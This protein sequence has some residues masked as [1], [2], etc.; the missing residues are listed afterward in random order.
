MVGPGDGGEAV[1]SNKAAGAHAASH[2]ARMST[3]APRVNTV[4]AQAGGVA[5][6]ICPGR[7]ANHGDTT[8]SVI[9]PIYPSTTY[10]RDPETYLPRPLMGAARVPNRVVAAAIDAPTSNRREGADDDEGRITTVESAPAHPGKNV[11]ARPDNPTY[12]QAEAV[13]AALDGGVGCALF[14]SGMA[15]A[16]G[17]ATAL[18]KHGDRCVFPRHSYFACREYFRQHCARIGCEFRLYDCRKGK[19]HE[20]LNEGADPRTDEE[21]WRTE[22]SSVETAIGTDGKT[23]LVWIETPANPTWDVTDVRRV[24]DRAHAFGASVCVDNTVLTPLCCAPIRLGADFVM[25]SAT[26]YLNGH[27][28][29]VAGAVVAAVDDER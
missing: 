16:C 20:H 4:I 6:G 8:G 2:P 17:L 9:P 11:Y 3:R 5:L 27:S 24:C 7:G 29:V 13:I 1:A 23:K 14:S 25:H 28:D 10:A 18:L 26:K 12:V 19:L 22:G 15:A 21:L